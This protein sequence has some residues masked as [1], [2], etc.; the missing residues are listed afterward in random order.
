MRAAAIWVTFN[1]NKTK[2]RRKAK[3]SESY[4]FIYVPLILE[5]FFLNWKGLNN[6][7]E[8]I[9]SCLSACYMR[10]DD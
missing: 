6:F 4:G 7:R 9:E 2:A 10:K 8:F 1:D 5:E 3:L